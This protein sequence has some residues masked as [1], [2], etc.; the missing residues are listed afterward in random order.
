M[1]K[2]HGKVVWEKQII[3]VKRGEVRTPTM[4]NLTSS[5]MNSNALFFILLIQLNK[6]TI[7]VG[8]DV[9]FGPKCMSIWDD[10]KWFWRELEEWTYEFGHT[11]VDKN[12]KN[13]GS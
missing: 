10:E 11:Y 1:D 5:S 8:S 7:N 6:Q 12:K 13:C 2:E 3:R 4:E 9:T